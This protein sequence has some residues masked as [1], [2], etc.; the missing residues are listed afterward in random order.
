MPK[1][2]ARKKALTDLKDELGIKHAC[3]I[4]LLDHPDIDERRLLVEYLAEYVDITTYREAVDYLRQEQANPLDYEGP[5][6]TDQLPH[7]P[8]I[9]A[10]AEAFAAYDITVIDGGTSTQDGELLEGWITFAPSNISPDTW[11]HGVHLG[12]DQNRGWHLIESGGG[13]NVHELDPEAVLTY[14]S[15]QQVACSAANALRGYLSTGPI[16]DGSWRT[17]DSRSVEAAVAAWTADA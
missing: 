3:A 1:D 17:W 7:D 13:R 2:H 8:Y 16:T 10:V 6:M 15:P 12:W 5:T 9:S 11:Q 14:S 4:A